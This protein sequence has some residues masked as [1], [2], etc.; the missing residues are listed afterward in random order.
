MSHLHSSIRLVQSSVLGC[1]DSIAR[2]HLS[3]HEHK[4]SN[5]SPPAP[6][7][8]PSIGHA[9]ISLCHEVLTPVAYESMKP[10]RRL[11]TRENLREMGACRLIC[12]VKLRERGLGRLSSPKELLSPL[13]LI[14]PQRKRNMSETDSRLYPFTIVIH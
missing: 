8:C 1:G 6:K 2:S 12:D 9:L 3:S 11:D 14:R 13:V 10:V 5:S 7:L 4:I